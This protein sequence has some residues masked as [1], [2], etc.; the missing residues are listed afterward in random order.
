M[1]IMP[2]KNLISPIVGN[3]VLRSIFEEERISKKV[4]KRILITAVSPKKHS[5]TP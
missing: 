4:A 3:Y 2:N 5:R 1:D